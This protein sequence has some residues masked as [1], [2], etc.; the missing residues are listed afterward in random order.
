MTAAPAKPAEKND[1]GTLP[2]WNLGDLYVSPSDPAIE[3]DLQSLAALSG[4]FKRQFEG[5]LSGLSGAD[6]LKALLDFEKMQDLAGRVGSYAQLAYAGN[7]TDP[8][9]ARFQQ[10][11]SERLNNISVETLFFTLELN[12]ID[13]A[14]LAKQ[15]THGPLQRY[16]PWLESVRSFRPHQLSDEAE[17]LLHEK[18]ISGRQA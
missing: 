6:L 2:N 1:L 15:L 7:M 10:N 8:E 4:E 12:K 9:L 16:Q 18:S 13:D 11:I 5:K 17:R 14:V 3:R